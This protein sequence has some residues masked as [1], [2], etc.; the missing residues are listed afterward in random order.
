MFHS[1]KF[2]GIQIGIS[3]YG[4]TIFMC[5]MVNNACMKLDTIIIHSMNCW[6]GLLD[7]AK[8]KIWINPLQKR[9]VL[10]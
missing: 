8:L 3:I 1:V 5:Y 9:L 4:L 10:Q 6:N 7:E 2:Q